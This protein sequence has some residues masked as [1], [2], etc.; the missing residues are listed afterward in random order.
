[1]YTHYYIYITAISAEKDYIR[2][3]KL[4]KTQPQQVR[5]NSFYGSIQSEA[6]KPRTPRSPAGVAFSGIETPTSRA[7]SRRESRSESI[8]NAYPTPRPSRAGSLVITGT[9]PLGSRTGSFLEA[10]PAQTQYPF[11]G[12]SGRRSSFK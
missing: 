11:G 12:N 10:V 4:R 1:M 6:S 7:L 8:A 5:Y 9:T 3:D 2:F